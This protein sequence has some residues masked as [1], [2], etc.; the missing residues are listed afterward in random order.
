VI[1]E[2]NVIECI[3]SDNGQ[4]F[5]SNSFYEFCAEKNIKII[6]TLPYTPWAKGKFFFTLGAIERFNQTL[7]NNI[8]TLMIRK[9]TES[10]TSCLAEALSIYNSSIHSTTNLSP[11]HLHAIINIGK[12]EDYEDEEVFFKKLRLKLITVNNI[13]KKLERQQFSTQKKNKGESYS[14]GEKIFIFCP[15]IYRKKSDF[16]FCKVGTIQKFGKN[17]TRVIIK[18]GSTG[19]W[20]KK[21][22]VNSE[23]EI[24]HSVQIFRKNPILPFFKKLNYWIKPGTYI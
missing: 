14:V 13:V 17:N 21:H 10:W 1:D 9:N 5:K 7:K 3:Y 6:E 19:G 12:K 11:N 22:T 16:P 24:H 15:E 4:E 18:F 2:N 20:L 23:E 8:R